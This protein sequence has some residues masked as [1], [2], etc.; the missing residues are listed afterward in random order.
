V[1]DERE[2]G[3]AAS[4]VFGRAQPPR[5]AL[6]TRGTFVGLAWSGVEGAGNKIV[7]AS[8]ECDRERVRLARLW[9]PFADAPGRRDVRAR[10]APWLE[11]Q[12]RWAEGRLVVGV[13]FPLSLP[14]L[15]VRQLGLLRQA[16][17]GPAVLG[18]HLEERFLGETGDFT[19]AAARLRAEL[20]RDQRRVTDCYRAELQP[21]TSPRALRRTFFGLVAMARL[22]AAFVPWEPPRGSGATIVEVRPA[23][24]ARELCGRCD[25]RDDAASGSRR[26]ARATVLRVLRNAARIE[27]QM[28]QA[29]P[30]VED[31]SGDHLEALLAAVGAAAA[32]ADGF[33]GVPHDVPRCEG[34][35]YSV[36]EEPWRE[37][38]GR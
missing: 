14:E 10:F 33:Q 35:I 23:H 3:G 22:D 5:L 31:G 38:P 13:D 11:E 17:R 20:G 28:E 29:A 37:G 7:A 8:L 2:Q 4:A 21:P 26:S 16:L 18:K 19:G 9:R 24:V 27:F 30:I 6:P 34:W 32:A 12:L 15:H 1:A 36:R 25:T